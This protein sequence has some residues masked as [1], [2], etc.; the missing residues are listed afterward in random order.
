MEPRQGDGIPVAPQAFNDSLTA[1]EDKAIIEYVG[2]LKDHGFELKK[3]TMVSQIASAYLKHNG[4]S[5]SDQFAALRADCRL[6]EERIY[7][8]SDMAYATTIQ[9]NGRILNTRRRKA[10][11][12]RELASIIYCY[13]AQGKPLSPTTGW[14]EKTHAL[15][16]LNSVFEEETSPSGSRDRGQ[17]RE[18]KQRHLLLIDSQ[19]P[20]TIPR[21]PK[22]SKTPKSSRKLEVLPSLMM[23]LEEFQ[24]CFDRYENASPAEKKRRREEVMLGYARCVWKLGEFIQWSLLSLKKLRTR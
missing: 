10:S 2:Q 21:T 11:E 19:F 17:R 4:S 3:Q 5:D 12:H 18:R 22:R 6:N 8:L 23:S 1:V 24:D 14:A 15:D 9:K 7:A 20:V 16:W 13:P